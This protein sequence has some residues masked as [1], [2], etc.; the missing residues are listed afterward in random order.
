M[1]APEP[2][3]TSS[4]RAPVPSAIFLDMIEVAISGIASTVPV[5]SR[6]AYSFLS[7]GA[8]PSPAAQITAPTDSSW[9]NISWLESAARHPGI[10]SSLSSVPPVWPRPAAGELGYGDPAGRD[11]RCERQRDLV[12]D[13]AGGV[14]VGGRSG[15]LR[16]IHPLPRRDHRV[17]PAGDLAAVHPVEQDRHRQRGHLLVGDVSPRVGVDDPVDLAVAEL[18][19]VALGDDHLDGVVLAHGLAPFWASVTWLRSSGP[20]AW[21]ST[22]S[23]VRSPSG[24]ISTSDPPPCS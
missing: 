1:N 11:E 10:D 22:S 17:G 8:S 4:T 2:T 14:L 15:Q 5:T 20:K 21:G 3:L 12:A 18:A 7:A 16:E 6:R 9:S 13:P 19:P 24:V 23:M